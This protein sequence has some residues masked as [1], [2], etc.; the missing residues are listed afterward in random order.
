MAIYPKHSAARYRITP[1]AAAVMATAYP[2]ELSVAQNRAPMLEEVI[3]TAT[4]RSLDLQD[5]PQ[6]IS[7]FTTA[8]IEKLGLRR[9]NDYIKA[10]PSVTL[11]NSQPGRNS[12]VFRGVSTGSSEYRTD[13]MTA[14]YLD[15]QPMTTNSQQVDPRLIDIERVE[16]LPG[17][18]GTLFGSSSQAGTLRII[19]NK[20]NFDGVT[21]QVDAGVSTTK[22]GEESYD[23][24]GH[25]N[26]PLSDSFAI[27][28]VGFYSRE[29]G[30]IDNVLGSDLA[31]LNTNADVV[32]EDYNEYTTSGGR[33]AARWDISE[34]WSVL[35]GVI[36]QDGEANGAWESDPAIGELQIVKFFDEFRTDDWY[37]ASF[38]I[39]GD[40][41]FAELS[42][43]TAYFDREIAYEWDNM[44]YEQY[45][46]AYFGVY[47]G[48]NLYNS[49]YTFG[50]IFNDQ[51][52]ERFSQEIRLT[53]TGDSK[54]QWMLGAFYEDVY[55][56]WFY[57]ARNAALT[58]TL[59]FAAANAYAYYNASYYDSIQYPLAPTDIGYS[60]TFERTI[61]QK[62]VFGEVDYSLT[63]QWIASVGAR[64]FEYDREEL[65]NFQFPLGLPPF[66]AFDSGGTYT[67]EGK[68]SNTALKFS[69]K[70]HIDDERMVYFTFSQGFRLGGSNSQRAAATGL[71]PQEYESDELNNY[72]I[73]LKSRWFEDRF[74]LNIS[75]FFMEWEGIQINN[76]GGVDSQ[77]WLRGTINGDTAEQTGAEVNWTAQLTERLKFEGSLFVADPQFSSEFT[78]L[79][80]RQIVD[81]TVMPIS[82][83]FKYWFAFEYTIPEVGG[84][85][86][87]WFRYDQSYQAEVF[88]SVESAIDND[89]TGI[90]PSWEE[91]NF[92][93]GFSMGED[94]DVT[95]SVWNVWDERSINWLDNGINTYADQFGDNRF[96]NIRS[97]SRPRSIGLSFT[98]RFN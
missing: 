17:P 19:T 83:D 60:N 89:P 30:Y 24:S 35:A 62:A 18:Q 82:P 15:E 31:A 96:R 51:T 91:A 46:D 85:G 47:L 29:G 67:A 4:K 81:G 56:E 73:G 43:T 25:I 34:D 50:T 95:L 80:G 13:S 61:K 33:I 20:P 94:V 39:T 27:R 65:D 23:L 75:L 59:A 21:G 57:G 74:E 5:V 72:E 14:V 48:Y 68:E 88:N 44:A 76:E 6:S 93:A 12:V 10:L 1:L 49:E 2:W 63:D 78:L 55:D 41:G 54:L 97:Y 71:V 32:E 92:Q 28:A 69:T 38:T 40:L 16:A 84:L 53:S 87:L 7:A 42:A 45:K 37:Q 9:M 36:A 58:D 86:D 64:W 3:V 79:D 8:D 98:K 70:Y 52:Q 11:I 90:H 26:L 77:W 66:G 22:G